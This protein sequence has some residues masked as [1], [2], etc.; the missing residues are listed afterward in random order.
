MDLCYNICMLLLLV[1]LCC[2][3]VQTMST[4][5][6]V[7]KSLQWIMYL[8]S[9]CMTGVVLNICCHHQALPRYLKR[10]HI[11]NKETSVCAYFRTCVSTE[12]IKHHRM[13]IIISII[14]IKFRCP[15]LCIKR[16]IISKIAARG[17]R[18]R[19][20]AHWLLAM[21][22]FIWMHL[23]VLVCALKRATLVWA[24]TRRGSPSRG[25]HNVLLRL[26]SCVN[27]Y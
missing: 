11:C 27:V 10:T 9:S 26:L 4:D 20:P 15:D 24:A 13:H 17:G 18:P 8:S 3:Y 16:S 14:G 2:A 12:L 23:V 7:L 6:D 21:F 1:F 19:A 25:R 22:Y 5:N